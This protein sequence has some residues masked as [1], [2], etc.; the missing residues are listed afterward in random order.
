[1][2]GGGLA[3]RFGRRQVIVPSMLM[4]SIG[5]GVLAM[6]G[7]VADS[8]WVPLLSLFFLAGVLTGGAHGFLYPALSALVVDEAPKDR[9]G[10]VVG[11]FSASVLI[12]NTVGAVLFGYIAHGLGYG[13]MLTLL[14]TMLLAGFALSLRLRPG[15]RTHESPQLF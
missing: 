3:D 6:L 14:A 12:G 13:P 4:Q 8:A 2:L 1:M 15:P 7:L 9:R 5:V 11:M 10:R